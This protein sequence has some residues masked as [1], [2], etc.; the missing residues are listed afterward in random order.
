MGL[1]LMAPNVRPER[2]AL[3][4]RLALSWITPTHRLA[5]TLF[6]MPDFFEA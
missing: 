2:A 1:L 5:T 4:A 3:S 6:R